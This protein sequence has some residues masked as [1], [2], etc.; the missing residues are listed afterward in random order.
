MVNTVNGETAF[1]KIQ[2]IDI[3]NIWEMIYLKV[4]DWAEENLR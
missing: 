3:I 2:L 4:I 1:L